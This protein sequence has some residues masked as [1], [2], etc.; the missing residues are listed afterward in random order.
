MACWFA[1]NFNNI[2]YTKRFK[3]CRHYNSAYRIYGINSNREIR[4]FRI[5]STSTK[6]KFKY[7]LNMFFSIIFFGNVYPNHRLQQI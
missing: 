5:A 2:F 4:L 1:I 6:S 7:V 3:N